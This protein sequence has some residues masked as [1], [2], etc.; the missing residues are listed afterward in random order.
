MCCCGR[1]RRTVISLERGRYDPGLPLAFGIARLFDRAI[2]EL[3]H[4]GI[5]PRLG[6]A[7]RRAPEATRAAS[8]REG[9]ARVG[10]WRA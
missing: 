9:G 7:R 1:H 8:P 6:I 2:E 5:G 4:D 3:F 10:L